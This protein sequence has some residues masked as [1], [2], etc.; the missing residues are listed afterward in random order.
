MLSSFKPSP[1]RKSDS[2]KKNLSSLSTKPQLNIPDSTQLI[3]QDTT[4]T[5]NSSDSLAAPLLTKPLALQPIPLA[6]PDPL[7]P[8][9]QLMTKQL[10]H[11]QPYVPFVQEISIGVESISLLKDSWNLLKNIKKND[12]NR[13]YEYAGSLAILF[14][15]NIQLS[16]EGGYANL[17]PDHRK[18]NRNKYRSTGFY[19]SIGLD[20]LTR[21]SATDNLYAGLRYSRASFTNHTLP[22]QPVTKPI[23][24]DLTASWFELVLGSESLLLD[25]LNLYGGFTLCIGYLYNFEAFNPARN[26]VIPGYGINANKFRP[27]LNLYILYKFSFIERMIELN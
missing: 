4:L 9:D 24:Q 8:L 26:Y 27:V 22:D 10:I 16:I 23:S 14:R 3:D 1:S 20:Y 11:I 17:Y 7:P 25:K 2:K 21:Y 13:S 19:G 6:S 18:D 12:P 15:K 5:D